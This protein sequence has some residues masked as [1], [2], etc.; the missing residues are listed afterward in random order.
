MFA[1]LFEKALLMLEEVASVGCKPPEVVARKKELHKMVGEMLEQYGAELHQEAY[2][3]E[4]QAAMRQRLRREREEQ[5]AKVRD[6][7]STLAKVEALDDDSLPL[8]PQIQNDP[9]SVPRRRRKP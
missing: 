9:T 8:P 2:V 5:I 6:K 1:V 7:A 3:P 4:V